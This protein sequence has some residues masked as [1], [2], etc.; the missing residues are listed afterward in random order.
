MTKHTT[1]SV[2]CL[3][4]LMS[5][6][7]CAA[8]K[9]APALNTG[10]ETI[11]KASVNFED[12]SHLVQLRSGTLSAQEDAALSAFLRSTGVTYADRITMQTSEVSNA[13]QS[14]AA[15]DTVLSRIGL[16][17]SS[18]SLN[19]SVAPGNVKL[20]VSHSSVA[21]PQCG[22]FD[23]GVSPNWQN[24]TMPDYGCA[25]RSNLASMV[26]NP[27]DLVS[28]TPLGSISAA[29]VAKPVE[30]WNVLIQTG[31]VGSRA[32]TG[33]GPDPS[34]KAGPASLSKGGGSTGAAGSG[35]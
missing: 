4:A 22:H 1:T 11:Y 25:T 13:A 6:A 26:A 35:G 20:I 17:I 5:L 19:A 8:D 24:Q 32:W 34:T 31:V 33:T 12:F 21:L 3:L 28:G 2:A 16:T 29:A 14:R 30:S 9:T 10:L 7:G 27:A 15:V 23:R 18:V